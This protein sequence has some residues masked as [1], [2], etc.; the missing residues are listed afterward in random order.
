[1]WQRS[2]SQ[3]EGQQ[4]TPRHDPPRLARW[5]LR[6]RAARDV[7]DA[8]LR[9]S[10][11]SLSARLRRRRPARGAAPVSA[12]SRV[13]FA[14]LPARAR[15]RSPP[16]A[17]W[18]RGCRCSISSSALRMLRRYPGLTIVGGL[19]MAF[20][21]AVGTAVFAFINQ[22]FYPTMPLPEGDRIVAV[23]L[24]D[25]AKNAFEYHAAFDF[26]RWRAQLDDD[27]GPHRVS[28]PRAQPDHE[29]RARRAGAHRR[30][31]RVACS[32]DRVAPIH[33][34]DAQCRR[35]AARRTAGHRCRLQAVAIALSRRSRT[36]SVR[37]CGSA[38]DITTLVGVMPD[39]FAFPIQHDA[40][41]PLRLN[42]PPDAPRQGPAIRVFG[43]LDARRHARAGA[44]R[45]GVT[46]RADGG[47]VSR[48]ARAPAAAG[49]AVREAP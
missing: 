14:S 17:C 35:R 22:F 41:M 45:T 24:Y 33:G 39:G 6:A 47:G 3:R 11:R 32:G 44:K 40:W 49:H 20:A 19:A 34:R 1:M 42:Q 16:R 2:R 31:D 5:I 4:V 27:P 38:N 46:R 48:N 13:V 37:R 30:D 10:R 29:R 36:R 25:S 18:R 43:R 21:I 28:Q 26:A 7:R 23:R 15:P 9:R 8:R 12:Q